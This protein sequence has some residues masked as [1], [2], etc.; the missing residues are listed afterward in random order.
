MKLLLLVLIIGV[1]VLY[2][3]LKTKADNNRTS[4]GVELEN[5]IGI[6]L[7]GPDAQQRGGRVQINQPGQS[8]SN[9]RNKMLKL[10]PLLAIGF[11]LGTTI[12]SSIYTIE[13]DEN[14]VVTRFQKKV[15]ITD[16]GIHVKIPFIDDVIKV[17]TKKIH[18]VEFG[19]R[20]KRASAGRTE[21][22]DK[23]Y[24]EESKM[25]TGDLNVADVEWV[26]QFQI[27]DA[28][29][30]LFNTKDPIENIKDISESV[31]RRLVGDRLVSDV[32]TTGRAEI[33][34]KGKV[35]IQDILDGYEQGV[36]IVNI[37]LQDIN[38][39]DSVKTSFNDVNNAKQEQ[40]K[41]I[42]EAEQEYNTVIP[43]AK[44]KAEE[45]IAVAQGQAKERINRALGDASKFKKVLKE[46]K[47]APAITRKRLYLETMEHIM[48]DKKILLVEPSA[49]KGI[50]PIYD[51]KTTK[52]GVK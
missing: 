4:V 29:D 44:G 16:P 45:R 24:S 50:Y 19:F 36:K 37:Q 49:Q 22:D 7:E 52:K 33:S 23:D 6:F 17:Q 18:Q 42:N 1:I 26:V 51:I 9:N 11:F 34:S 10:L 43:E 15:D 12:L 47:K 3:Y 13:P 32:L 28:A 30:Y 25:L 46:Y 20:T 8:G 41:L 35:L 38:P 2:N 21:Y 48:K 31:M 14:G 27:S 5:L 39:P 40:D